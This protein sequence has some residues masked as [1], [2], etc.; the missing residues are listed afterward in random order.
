[1]IAELHAHSNNSDGRDSVK[2]LITSAIE[3][4]IEA[5]SI[6]DHNTIGGSL[7]A[8]ELVEDEHLPILVIPGVEISTR[9]GH[10]LAYGITDDIDSGM[11][12]ENTAREVRKNGGVSV[13]AHP[14]QIHK[15]GVT[16]LSRIIRFIEA[17]EVFNA[18]FYIGLCNKFSRYIAR[19][20]NKPEIAGS[21]AHTVD[22]LGH[23]ITLLYNANDVES[24]LKDIRYGF[25]GVIGYRIPISLQLKTS[26]RGIW[27][28]V[29]GRY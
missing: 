2:N 29:V 7:E 25:T 28:G 9:D 27:G 6:T 8:M 17:V 18:K 10:L 21:D 4:G 13:V 26:M 19:K 15:S 5:I 20:F 11:G 14:F 23:G 22:A 16:S 12:M 24:A 3:K 1:M